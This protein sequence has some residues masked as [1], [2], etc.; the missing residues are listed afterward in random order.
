METT[1]YVP[2]QQVEINM[3]ADPTKPEWSPVTV[4][5]VGGSL[6]EN[7]IEIKFPTGGVTP[8]LLRR[9]RPASR[10]MWSVR[11]VPNDDVTVRKLTF[12]SEDIANG[13]R[14]GLLAAGVHLVAEVTSC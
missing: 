3:S 4:Y 6:G 1:N 9:V 14:I 12:T 5:R 2:D 8:I 13:V 11:Y 10:P 7:H